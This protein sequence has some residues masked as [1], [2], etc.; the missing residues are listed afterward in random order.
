[1]VRQELSNFELMQIWITD[2]KI[3]DL[4]KQ[5]MKRMKAEFKTQAIPLHVIVDPQ[6]KELARFDYKGTLSTAADYL[7]FL[8]EGLAKYE[9]R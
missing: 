1:V 4:A 8:K 2:P 7:A 3:K 6:G 9:K 5:Q